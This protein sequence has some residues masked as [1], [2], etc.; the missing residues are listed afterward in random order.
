MSLDLAS[1]RSREFPRF[2]TEG[3]TYLNAAS[4]G[5]LPQRTIDGLAEFN[6][7]RA[8]PHTI[9]DPELF[10]RLARARDLIARL[11]GA[12]PAEIALSTN[13]GFGIN[14]AAA[15]LPLGPGDVIL[16]P[17][18]EFPANVYPWMAHAARRGAEYRRVPLGDGDPNTAIEQALEGDRVKV[19]SVSW[20]GFA[21]GVRLDLERLGRRCRERGTWFVVDAIQGLGP[22]TIDLSTTPVDILACGG[23]KWLLSPW[24]SGFT[25][26]RRELI[27]SLEPA[28]VG[29][30]AVQG[31]D[32][33]RRLLD[34]DITWRSDAR[35]YEV[36]TL[37]LQDFVGMSLSLELLHE[38]GPSDVAQHCAELAG[39]F[40]NWASSRSDVALLTPAQPELRAG[41]VSLAPG[42][43]AGASERLKGAGVAH[44]Q[45][46]GALRFSP[47]CYNTRDEVA[48]VLSLLDRS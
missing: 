4:T 24:G 3:I 43:P 29:W 1:L 35:R 25:Y 47:H 46:E 28:Q 22:L 42:D 7:R 16:T 14:L 48:R 17:D 21:S 15:S 26:V 33:F 41:I 20:V 23:Q 40:V 34:Y 38:L 37:P 36:L 30:T 8:L 19:L 2:D 18:L 31:P 10:D 9:T 32:D 5:P 45:R 12:A 6:A 27:D 39:M 13:T 44:S 11:V